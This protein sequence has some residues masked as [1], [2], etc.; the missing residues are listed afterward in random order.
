MRCVFFVL[1]GLWFLENFHEFWGTPQQKTASV[2]VYHKLGNIGFLAFSGA[3]GF[4][5]MK[6]YFEEAAE[7]DFFLSC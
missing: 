6:P 5:E 7:P 1:F 4:A 2:E 3:A